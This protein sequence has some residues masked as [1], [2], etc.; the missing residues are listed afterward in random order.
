MLI[1]FKIVL[2]IKVNDNRF[3]QTNLGLESTIID[4]TKK[5]YLIKRMGIISKKKSLTLPV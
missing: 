3:W 1:M 4:I 5:P 2:G